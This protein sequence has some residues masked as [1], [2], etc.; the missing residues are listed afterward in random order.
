MDCLQ[1]SKGTSTLN[2]LTRFVVPNPHAVAKNAPPVSPH[3][4]LQSDAWH[5]MTSHLLQDSPTNQLVYI[6]SGMGGVGKT[7]LVSYFIQEHGYRY[8][9]ILFLDAR[10]D[11]GVCKDIQYAVRSID[12]E[13]SQFTWEE[14]LQYL[15]A[16]TNESNW[17]MV[18]DNADDPKVKLTC[19]FPQCSHGTII[20]TTRNRDHGSLANVPHWELKPMS[21]EQAKMKAYS[22]FK[23]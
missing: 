6:L 2:K 5:S 15:S 14:G 17:L 23:N 7:Q 21:D 9:Q 1:G 19:Y 8:S 16:K 20:V 11:I 12:P 3:F 22:W 4:E 18:F 10:S 13:F